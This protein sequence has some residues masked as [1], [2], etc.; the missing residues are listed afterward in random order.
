M[1]DYLWSL[2]CNQGKLACFITDFALNG[3]N[4]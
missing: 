4:K 3:V 2:G 1:D